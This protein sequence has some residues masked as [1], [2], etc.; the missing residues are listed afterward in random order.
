M[1]LAL[2]CLKYGYKPTGYGFRVSF[3]EVKKVHNIFSWTYVTVSAKNGHQFLFSK[4][5]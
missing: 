1:M 5:K 4:R 3:L 2:F